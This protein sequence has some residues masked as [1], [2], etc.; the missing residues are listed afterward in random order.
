[1]CATVVLQRA[2][3]LTSKQ[4]KHEITKME[5]DIEASN[6]ALCSFVTKR[7][8]LYLC[9]LLD[10]SVLPAQSC[11]AAHHSLF[12]PFNSVPVSSQRFRVEFSNREVELENERAAFKSV[13]DATLAKVNPGLRILK[14]VPYFTAS[15]YPWCKMNPAQYTSC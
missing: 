11:S 8:A 4:R 9:M 10:C 2:R 1:M 7:D 14:K 15:V 3:E 13:L 5:Q 12:V 6:D